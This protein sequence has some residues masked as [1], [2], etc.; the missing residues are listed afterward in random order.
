MSK[1]DPIVE[2]V[3][4]KFLQRSKVGI[5]KYGTTLHENNNDNFL[6]HLQEELMDAVNYIEKLQSP[7]EENIQ[8]KVIEW[9]EERQILCSD[10]A[11]KQI[12]KLTEEVGELAA[13]FLK[14]KDSEVKDA[15]GDI[16]VVL[17]I[18]CEQLGIDYKQCLND[19]YD[20]IKDRKGKT[21]NGTFIR[22]ENN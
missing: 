18:L 15:I 9:A 22:D 8:S 5:E 16:Q 12:I 2:S 21:E 4:Y 20:V 19:A 3:V 14:S 17:I 7:Q 11:P 6:N 10:N 1:T 13:A